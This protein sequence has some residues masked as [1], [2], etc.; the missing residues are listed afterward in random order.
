[1]VSGFTLKPL[2][3]NLRCSIG[4]KDQSHY[5]GTLLRAHRFLKKKLDLGEDIGRQT[6][7]RIL[8][9]CRVDACSNLQ[10]V[11]NQGYS[12]MAT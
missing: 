2:A 4:K 5:R 6:T 8:T 7:I 9:I 10:T 12:S 11:K 1:M 3:D